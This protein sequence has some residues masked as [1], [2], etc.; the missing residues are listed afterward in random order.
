[1]LDEKPPG[2]KSNAETIIVLPRMN[3]VL[4]LSSLIDPIMHILVIEDNAEDAFLILQAFTAIDNCQA[5]VCRNVGEARAYLDGSGM[6]ANR[7]KYP[8]PDAIISDLALIGE[9]GL[10]FIRWLQSDSRFQ[11]IPTVILSGAVSQKDI[12]A[13]QELGVL[14]VLQKPHDLRILERAFSQLV[15]ELH[16]RS[17][18]VRA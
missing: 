14:R 6:F 13:A 18:I 11:N 5:F 16:S 15:E 2:L 1:M 7:R 8:R 12:A 17:G 3:G 9:S 4:K 10:E